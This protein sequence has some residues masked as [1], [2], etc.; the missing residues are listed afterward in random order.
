MHIIFINPQGNFDAADSHLTEHPDFGG[1]LVYVKELAMAMVEYGHQVDI[2]TRQIEDP[3]WPEFAAQIDYYPGYEKHLRILR[4]PCGGPQFLAKEHLWPY[5]DEFVGNLVEFYGNRL[6]EFATGHYAD[7]GYCAALL[8][9]LTG[10]GYTFTGHSL[11]A[12]KLDKLGM[13]IDNADDME[14]RYCFSRRIEAERLAMSRAFRIVTSTSQERDE[15]YSHPLYKDAV[16]VQSTGQ[17][18][19]V[20]P[21]VNL[22]I[23]N[24]Q[25]SEQDADTRKRLDAKLEERSGPWVIVSSRL[26]EKKNIIGVVKAYVESRILRE[27][28]SLAICI[29]GVDDPYAEIDK[30][31]L[32]EQVVLRPILDTIVDAGIKDKVVFLNLQSQRELAATYRYFAQLRSVFALTAFYEPFGLAPIEAAACGLV[33]VATQNGGPSE[34]FE[35]GSGVLVDPY[36]PSDIARGLVEALANAP[37]LAEKGRRRV[38][39]TYTWTKTAEGY[40]SIIATGA[41]AVHARDED[42]PE[43]NAGGRIRDY[44]AGRV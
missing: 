41:G 44:L 7:G 43:L 32:S 38:I 25:E 42:M 30:L 39:E 4:L 19:V 26:D 21:G 1:Q 10:I 23:F 40:L 2:V 3:G 27:Q 28:S 16:D 20:P 14:Q 36:E 29:R 11:G 6:P 37:L 15:Q 9:S 18:S 24:H 13:S 31:S 8:K 35:D 12:Q 34:I 17:F 5:L 33:C 22:K